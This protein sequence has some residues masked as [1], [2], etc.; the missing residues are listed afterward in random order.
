MSFIDLASNFN[1]QA[2]RC[3]MAVSQRKLFEIYPLLKVEVNS[4]AFLDL[5]IPSKNLVALICSIPVM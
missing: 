1:S 3:V 5:L 4:P 2:L